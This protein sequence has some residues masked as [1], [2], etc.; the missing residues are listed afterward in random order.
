MAIEFLY[1]SIELAA[2]L[3]LNEKL[4]DLGTPFQVLRPHLPNLTLLRP[5]PLGM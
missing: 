5:P 4:G 1:R 3:A 2:F